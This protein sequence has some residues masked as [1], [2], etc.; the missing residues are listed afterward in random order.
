MLCSLAC[1]LSWQVFYAVLLFA[2]PMAVLVCVLA[3]RISQYKSDNFQIKSELCEICIWL[4][5]HSLLL[6]FFL[7]HELAGSA[8]SLSV[9]AARCAV[10]LVLTVAAVFVTNLLVADTD[11]L[12][13]VLFT[14]IFAGKR[15]LVVDVAIAS[16]KFV[17]SNSILSLFTAGVMAWFHVI[18]MLL[19]VLGSYRF[20]REPKQTR[21]AIERMSLQQLL[22]MPQGVESLM[23]F[24][25]TEFCSETL[26]FY[27]RVADFKAQFGP[28]AYSSAP[29]TPDERRARFAEAIKVARDIFDLYLRPTS[30]FEV[31]VGY[32]IRTAVE[33]ELLKLAAAAHGS[34]FRT[35]RSSEPTV[36]LAIVPH[37]AA[38][39]AGDESLIA[40]T[41]V[42]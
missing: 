21:H 25:Q 2:V 17:V 35:L 32:E 14:A 23:H 7:V 5:A 42:S 36:A 40:P 41:H 22:T 18:S 26:I 11:W 34:S 38:G 13:P 30:A 12:H 9:F 8:H 4:P 15:D 31:N 6:S 28:I 19:P 24:L 39:A 29:Q 16:L 27:R 3:W 1:L 20:E 33:Q 10:C 37:S